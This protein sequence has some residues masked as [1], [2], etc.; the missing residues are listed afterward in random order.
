MQ[1]NGL[2]IMSSDDMLLL[3]IHETCCAWHSHSRD[4][5]GM[6]DGDVHDLGV[7]DVIVRRLD[8]HSV[9]VQRGSWIKSWHG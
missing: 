2:D 8:V 4:W 5:A 1:E 3:I 7:H 9:D 6:H